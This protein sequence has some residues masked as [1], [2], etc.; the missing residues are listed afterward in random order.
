MEQKRLNNGFQSDGVFTQGGCQGF[1]ADWAPSML[2]NQHG[3]QATITGIEATLV[4]AMQAERVNSLLAQFDKF[5]KYKGED[6]PKP[7]PTK[8]FTK[9]LDRELDQQ[10]MR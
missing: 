10:M 6:E 8:G 2:I 1:Q 4:N 5:E 7:K 9:E 3:E